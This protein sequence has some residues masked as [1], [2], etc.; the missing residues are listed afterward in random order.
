MKAELPRYLAEWGWTSS[1]DEFLKYWFESERQVDQRVLDVAMKL[2][3]RGVK[4]YLVSDNEKYRAEYLMNEVGLKNHFDG[5]FFSYDL[6]FKK[7]QQEF[8]EKILGRL[9]TSAGEVIY[10]DDDEK[11]AEVAKVFR[12]DARFYSDFDEFHESVSGLSIAQR[13]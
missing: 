7:S 4:C 8:F 3:E 13:F 9:S 5:A 1:L 12:I 2:R 6:G 10:W 11:N